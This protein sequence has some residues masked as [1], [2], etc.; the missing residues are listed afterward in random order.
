M[1]DSEGQS[2]SSAS[3]LLSF[4]DRGVKVF[5]PAKSQRNDVSFFA[6]DWDVFG[7]RIFS[8]KVIV[9]ASRSALHLELA[10][11]GYGSNGASLSDR[12]CG[13]PNSS[14]S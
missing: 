4:F 5:S 12:R 2:T 10:R 8:P 7:S 11:V 1:G 6:K 3:L 14:N 13:I 9:Y